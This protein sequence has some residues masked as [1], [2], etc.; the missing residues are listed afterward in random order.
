MIKTIIYNHIHDV[1]YVKIS[2][3]S[4]TWQVLLVVERLSKNRARAGQQRILKGFKL[5]LSKELCS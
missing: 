3:H 4:R 5:C 2:S 1:L